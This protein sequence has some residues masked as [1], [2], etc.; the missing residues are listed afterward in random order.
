MDDIIILAQNKNFLFKLLTIK[1]I[2]NLNKIFNLL[3]HS[4]IDIWANFKF[5][6]KNVH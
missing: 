3:A 5:I 1:K 2:F 4:F 6:E